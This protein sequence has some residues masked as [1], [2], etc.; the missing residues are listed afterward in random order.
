MIIGG[1]GQAGCAAPSAGQQRSGSRRPAL[2][3]RAPCLVRLGSK[4]RQMMLLSQ[5]NH[6][7][8]VMNDNYCVIQHD[9]GC[10]GTDELQ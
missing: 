6:H 4:P 3:L 8:I 2:L 10:V 9:E 1:A 7:S 5:I